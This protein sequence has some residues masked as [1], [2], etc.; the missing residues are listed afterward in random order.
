ML[1]RTPYGKEDGCEI[2]YRYV[3]RG[4]AVVV[5]DVRG[6]NASEGE[7][8]PNYHEV[9]DGDDTLNWIAA[10]HGAADASVWWAVLPGLCTVGSRCQRQPPPESSDQRSLRGQRL[11][12]SARRGGSFTSGMLAWA[13]A[14]SQ[15]TFHPELMERDDW[16]KVLNIRP[17][18]DLPKKALGYD[19]PFITRCWNPVTTTIS[20]VCP[21]G[22][23]A[24]SGRRS[25]R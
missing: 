8:L 5:Q 25:R 21:T 17:L 16:E 14:V 20:G 18:T 24:P 12:G 10:Q 3:Q 7:W 19:V 2:Y 23:N 13:F 9:E 1:V 11:C 22:R 6:R 4:Y 15:K